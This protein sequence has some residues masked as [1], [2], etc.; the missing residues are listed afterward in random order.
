MTK[1]DEY[2]AQGVNV[3]AFPADKMEAVLE[4]LRPILGHQQTPGSDTLLS[5]HG[6]QTGCT[7]TLASGHVDWSCTDALA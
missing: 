6:L 5:D 7:K 1:D 2:K 3:V 4:A